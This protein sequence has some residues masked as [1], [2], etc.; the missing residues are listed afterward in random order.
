[1]KHEYP[2]YYKQKITTEELRKKLDKKENIILDKFL[3][4]CGTT[5]NKNKV[6]D[7]ETA[8]VQ[9]RDIVGKRLYNLKK[10]DI[11]GFLNVLNNS[12]RTEWTKNGS[13][14]N[15]KRFLKFSY[16]DWSLRFGDLSNIKLR[17]GLNQLKINNK[18]LITP[19]E[20]KQM[21]IACSNQKD[22]ALIS[23]LYET[24]ARPQEV[25]SLK[26]ED[27]KFQEDGVTEI[28]F[29]S[30][31]TKASRKLVVKESTA[32]LKEHKFHYPYT[33]P[34]DD[35]IVFPPNSCGM[36]S[37]IKL[38]PRKRTMSDITL[39]NTVRKIAKKAGIKR[40]IYPY[41]FRHSRLTELDIKGV[42]EKVLK[43]YAGHKPWSNTLKKTYVHL[44]DNEFMI[45]SML[46]EVYDIKEFSKEEKQVLQEKLEKFEEKFNKQ[47]QKWEDLMNYLVSNPE[48]KV[49]DLLYAEKTEINSKKLDNVL[50]V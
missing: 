34:Q 49:K 37:N 22:R 1:M 19:D 29:Y 10:D 14:V 24:G 25:R 44:K 32:V 11:Y 2:D 6:R 21:M 18:T 20:L 7:V 16:P 23:L 46:S 8:I 30:G 39:S 3:V 28:N 27:I 15:L 50:A 12:K 42:S 41:L 38:E 36:R 4:F 17:Q 33:H 40:P 45:E 43:T 31:K 9:F 26:W 5:A 35:D 48:A 47:Y 13:K